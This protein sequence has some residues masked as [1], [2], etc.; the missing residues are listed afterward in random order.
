M[1]DNTLRASCFN[2]R[3][4]LGVRLPGYVAREPFQFETEVGNK[5]PGLS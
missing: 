2:S 4:R 1:G 3:R 5:T